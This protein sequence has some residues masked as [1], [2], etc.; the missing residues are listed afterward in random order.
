MT[1]ESGVFDVVRAAGPIVVEIPHAGLEI[2]ARSKA[3]VALPERARRARAIELDA[4][5]GADRIW[6]ESEQQGA[7]RVVARVSRYVIDL[8][9]DPRPPPRPP[10]YEADPA[11]LRIRRRSNAGVSW[12]EP[13]MPREEWSRRIAEIAEPYHVA[14]D[15]ELAHAK[16]HHGTVVLVSAHTFHD[17]TGRLSDVVLG[18]AHGRAAPATLRDAVAEVGR[19]HH[20]SVAL[21]EPFPGGYALA[22]HARPAEGVVALQ[23][24]MA[25]RLLTGSDDAG[26]VVRDDALTKLRA[27][28]ADILLAV[29][30]RLSTFG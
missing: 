18:T 14:I 3:F 21:E 17:P 9:T 24:E 10:F 15:G 25:R 8:N 6:G 1:V 19:A 20:F 23:I 16:R 28:A 7:T 30:H 5:V 13:A 4:D 26:A 29:T 2:D 11:P 22:R 12:S 27:F